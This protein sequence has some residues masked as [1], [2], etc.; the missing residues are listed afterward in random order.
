LE[1][2]VANDGINGNLMEFPWLF[3]ELSWQQNQAASS[4]Y[5]ESWIGGGCIGPGED[6]DLWS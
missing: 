3:T 2:V 4:L 1:K 6:D 5:S